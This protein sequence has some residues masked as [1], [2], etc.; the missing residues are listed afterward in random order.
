LWEECQFSQ[1]NIAMTL[2]GDALRTISSVSS[3]TR[4]IQ[5]VLALLRTHG[6][7]KSGSAVVTLRVA[8]DFE[9]TGFDMVNAWTAVS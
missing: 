2:F 5:Y 6:S 1:K 3:V 8:K 4:H 9:A 7:S